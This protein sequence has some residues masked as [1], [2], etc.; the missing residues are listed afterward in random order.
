MRKR[1]C[2][3]ASFDIVTRAVEDAFVKSV[4]AM[5]PE[6]QVLAVIR[7]LKELNPQFDGKETHKIEGGVV[8]MLSFSTVGVNDISP[9]KALQRLRMLNIAPPT[10]NQKGWLYD[11][12][13]LSEMQL[14]WLWCHNNP[15]TDL[16]PLKGM[17]LTV[18]SVSGTRV[19]DLSPLAGMKLE[20][21]SFNDTAVSDLSPLAGM[22]LSVLWC[23]DT[24]VAD[25]APLKGMSLKELRC[26]LV[27]ARDAEV[28]K[29]LPT[30]KQINNE[31]SLMF[32]KRLRIPDAAGL[33]PDDAKKD[34]KIALGYIYQRDS[35]IAESFKKLLDEAGFVVHLISSDDLIGNTNITSYAAFLI[36]SDRM[37]G[38]RQSLEENA[39]M[40]TVDGTRK[41]ILGLGEAGA[42]FFGALKLNII[43]PLCWYG[44]K[45]GIVPANYG[46]SPFWSSSKL[47]VK[48]GE[49]IT[50][51][52]ETSHVGAHQEKSSEGVSLIGAEQDSNDH[53]PILQQGSRYVL[54]GFSGAP[55]QMTSAGKQLFIAIC[56]YTVN[57]NTTRDGNTL[58]ARSLN[59]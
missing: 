16:S 2:A 21:L 53:F 6:Q 55:D 25:I 12:L 52:W 36:G 47:V 19:C 37:V 50:V 13:P 32:W 24:K 59:R 11:L 57:L 45:T 30:L 41:P 51:Y 5:Q 23:N 33:S 22:P 4:P 48:S 9:V 44:H 54:W 42:A 20:V 14:K 35:N 40:K 34:P 17:P 56:R 31:S 39:W 58:R 49:P 28:L 10:P 29:T 27:P 8:T 43:S 46:K 3:T 15:I 7:K 38:L 18:L 26:D 1:T